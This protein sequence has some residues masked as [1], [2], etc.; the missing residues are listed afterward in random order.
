VVD[1]SFAGDLD[2]WLAAAMEDE[3][4]R[5]GRSLLHIAQARANSQGVD[6]QTVCISGSVWENIGNYLRKVKASTLVIG[7]PK[8]VGTLDA[9]GSGDAE[10]VVDSLQR[11]TGIEV[12]VVT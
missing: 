2:D 7:L 10:E 5:L 1:P 3:L 12:V 6:A 8:S 11:S 9:F 4:R